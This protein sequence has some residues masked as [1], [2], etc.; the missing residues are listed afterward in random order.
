LPAIVAIHLYHR[1]FPP[2]VVGGIH[3]WGI[4]HEV[5]S[6]GR[7]REKLPITPSL[8][9]ELLAALM[10][11]LIL[12]QPR[13]GQLGRATHLVVV[14]DNS[15]SMQ[16]RPDDEQPAFYA[17]SLARLDEKLSDLNR[18]SLVTV[19]TT[20]T[21]PETIVGP[22]A[23]I[24]EAREELSKWLPSAARHDFAPAWDRAAQ[25]AG[26]AG[27]LV[28]LTDH[29]PPE[30]AVMPRR[31]ETVAVGEPLP[32][33]AVSAARWHVPPD[34]DTG[35][36]YLR[37]VNYSGRSAV[38]TVAGTKGEQT[39]FSE[40]V[41]V[42]PGTESP[43]LIRVPKGLGRIDV[44]VSTPS[45]GLDLD[46]RVTL[47][48]PQPRVI[49]VSV[50][51]PAGDPAADA[52]RK[53]LVLIPHVELVDDKADLVITTP[54]PLPPSDREL[55]WVGVGPLDRSDTARKAAKS[56]RGPYIL[57]KQNPLIEGLSL[58]GLIWGG[59]QEV[60]LDV[61]PLISADQ[62][63]LLARLNGTR[64]TAFLLNIDLE[65]SQLAES[66]NWPILVS[67]LV[68]LRRD[69]LPGLRRWNYRTGEIVRFRWPLS[70]DGGE[71]RLVYGDESRPL[72]RDT[73]GIVEIAG[74]DRP[75]VYEIREGDKLIDR[76]AVNFHDPRES[77]L[78]DLGHGE[79]QPE[80]ATA[81][82]AF[83]LDDPYS[84]LILAGLALVT[85]AALAD[86]TVLGRPARA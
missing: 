53:A 36:V 79:R 34:V 32:N 39:V 42:G 23:R 59:V 29:L 69:D 78:T 4:R 77:M 33:V 11:A 21:R 16:A 54:A 71:L 76:F 70:H 81:A 10:L 17:A 49:Q 57:E 40:T 15:A 61:D 9:L 31:M 5:R 60:G 52:F 35:E 84:W 25:F 24:D 55:W 64:T 6:A 63:P 19:L 28:F 72:A 74:L 48:E 14:L 26:E 27:E 3:L 67:N 46:D 66:E 7:T 51:L 2:L 83:R 82:E 68:E 44:R 18:G 1:R 75:G 50:R 73:R 12:A 37:L 22:A 30:A 20:G 58:G 62:L 8:L 45:D 85:L 65:Q 43:L 47:I 56:L 86:W 80:D 38:T 13:F 41:T